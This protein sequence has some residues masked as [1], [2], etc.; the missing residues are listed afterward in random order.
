MFGEGLAWEETIP[1]QVG[2]LMHVQSA[3]LAVHGYSTDQAFLRLQTALPHFRRPLAVVTLFMTA[4][5]GRNLDDDRPHLGPGLTWQPAEPHGRLVTLAGLIVPYRRDETVER[6]VGV[7]REVLRA[8]VALA[9]TRGA[10]PLIVVPQF[11]AEEPVETR[12][13]SR[14]L[15]ETGLPYVLVTVDSSWR[16]PWDRHPN[17]RAAALI[18]ESVATRL[19][20]V[21][22]E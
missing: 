18:A 2:A 7:S 16:L 9:H 20:E 1:A 21:K 19:R 6:G 17:A 3:N 10:A 14:I 15:D 8:M 12:L 13:R 4:L 11:G 22:G 5:F